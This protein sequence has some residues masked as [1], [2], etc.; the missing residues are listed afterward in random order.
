MPRRPRAAHGN[1]VFHV[2]NRAAKRMRLFDSASDY[3][4]AEQILLEARALTKMRLLAYCIMPNHWHLI[5]WPLNGEQMS[6]FMQW[7]TGTH[8]Q[9]WQAF[10][11]TIGTGAVYQGRYKAIPVQTDLYLLNVC[12]YVERNPLRAGL[13]QRAQ[14]WPWSSFSKRLMT[15][16]VLDNWPVSR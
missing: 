14:D 16:D 6:K 11:E 8:A 1:F 4:V 12:R 5:L 2:F 13:V 3:G 15:D 9:R 10:N 7:F